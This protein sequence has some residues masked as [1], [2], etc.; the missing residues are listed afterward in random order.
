MKMLQFYDYIHRKFRKL[1]RD[2]E[3]AKD[4]TQEFFLH[5][6]ENVTSRTDHISLRFIDRLIITI[7]SKMNQYNDALKRIATIVPLEDY[8]EDISYVPNV[9]ETIYTKQLLRLVYN[10]PES[11]LKRAIVILLAK[12]KFSKSTDIEHEQ[13]LY[14]K[15]EFLVNLRE[16]RH[17]E[18]VFDNRLSFSEVMDIKS[19]IMRGVSNFLIATKYGVAPD[20]ISKIK[21]GATWRT[22]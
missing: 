21:I 3:Q 10:L 8:Y 6:I 17:Y 5:Y 14:R 4:Y 9:I 2:N 11:K 13:A 16:D 15:K 18:E 1:L 19:M 22:V 20:V 7:M 12:G